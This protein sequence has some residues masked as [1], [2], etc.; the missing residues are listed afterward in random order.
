MKAVFLDS[1]AE[2]TWSAARSARAAGERSGE[3]APEEMAARIADAEIVLG[4]KVL[5]RDMLL[6]NASRLRFIGLTATGTDNVDLEAAH[7]RGIAVCNIRAYC[8]QSVAEHVFGCLLNLTHSLGPYVQ[9]VRAGA[10]QRSSVFCM[11]THPISELSGMTLGIVGFGEL[12]KGVAKIA[13]AFGMDVIV[14]ARPGSDEIPDGRVAF[15]DL[16]ERAD[17]ITLHCPLNDATRGLFGTR[18]FKTMKR[19]AILIN[20]ARGGLVDSQALARALR[21][22]DIHAAAIDVL[23]KEPPVDGDP[24]L[25]YGGDNLMLTPHIAWGTLRARQNAIDDLTANIRSFMDGGARN[26]IV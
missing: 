26:R 18:E 19:S 24:L 15:D 17:V 8:T 12:G 9:D 1:P 5:L 4:N 2:P 7:E 11:L 13:D 25:D 3:T 10:W 14:C 20:T 21:K 23:A 6:R 22:G 16:L